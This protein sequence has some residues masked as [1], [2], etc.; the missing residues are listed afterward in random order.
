M[1]HLEGLEEGRR[2]KDSRREKGFS[3]RVRWM[4]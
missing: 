2:E 4:L 1:S 3:V